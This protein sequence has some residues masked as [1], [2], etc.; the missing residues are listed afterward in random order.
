MFQG[1]PNIITLFNNG[2][3][4]T[5]INHPLGWTFNAV[6]QS[7]NYRQYCRLTPNNAPF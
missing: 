2:Q 6:P 3:L 5:N 7:I 4:L 1:I